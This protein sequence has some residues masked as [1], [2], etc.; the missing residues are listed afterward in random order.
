MREGACLPGSWAL[1]LRVITR[2]S[3]VPALGSGPHC[4]FPFLPGFCPAVQGAPGPRWGFSPTHLTLSPPLPL[5]LPPPS[6]PQGYCWGG[7]PH[8][9]FTA[10]EAEPSPALAPG[11][12]APFLLDL[13]GGKLRVQPWGCLAG[14]L[15]P[16][17][18]CGAQPQSLVPTGTR[19]PPASPAS[20]HLSPISL[21][22][23]DLSRQP[24]QASRRP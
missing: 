14:S 15:I 22:P 5:P 21:L 10:F 2:S 9:H 12:A 4:K 3:N 6:P 13:E 7:R 20:G 17:S 19:C 24:C 16:A 1:S 23:S 18:L 8:S 11:S